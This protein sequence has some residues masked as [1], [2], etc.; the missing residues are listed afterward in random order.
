MA[1]GRAV[2][3]CTQGDYIKPCQKDDKSPSKRA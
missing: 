2:I 3:L 1:K